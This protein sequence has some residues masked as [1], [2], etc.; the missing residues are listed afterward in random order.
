MSKLRSIIKEV[1]QEAKQVGTLYHYTKFDLAQQII[2]SGVL[3]GTPDLSFT[4]DKNFHRTYRNI[5]AKGKGMIAVRFTIDGNKLSNKYKIEPFADRLNRKYHSTFE[6]EELIKAREGE[7]VHVPIKDYVIS[8]DFL[9]EPIGDWDVDDPWEYLKTIDKVKKMG[10]PV[11]IVDDNGNP[12]SR[13]ERSK[14]AYW[15]SV[16]KSK[17]QK[18]LPI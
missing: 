6:A 8:M 13:K 5:G 2:N 4:R 18:V 7:V 15:F 14:M 12:F 17:L 11:N 1:L 10:I 16:Q 9:S 3:K